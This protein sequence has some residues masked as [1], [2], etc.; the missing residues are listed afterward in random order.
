MRIRVL[1]HR[2]NSE[3][4]ALCSIH[5]RTGEAIAFCVIKIGL[6]SIFSSQIRV[7]VAAKAAACY[8]V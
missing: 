2:H 3:A 5:E 7:I 4:I 8:Y 1:H 6:H